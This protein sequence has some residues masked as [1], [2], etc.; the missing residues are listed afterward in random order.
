MLKI[1]FKT[2]QLINQ[3]GLDAECM[4][5]LVN[6][7]MRVDRNFVFIQGK[8]INYVQFSSIKQITYQK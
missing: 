4:F 7:T 5:V 6:K 2:P 3:D 1:E 8:S